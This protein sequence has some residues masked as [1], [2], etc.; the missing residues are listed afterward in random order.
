MNSITASTKS[1]GLDQ[2]IW[3]MIGLIGLFAVIVVKEIALPS[4]VVTA[5]GA[6][7]LLGLFMMGIQYPEMPFY[8]LVAYVPFSKILTGDFGTQAFALNMTNILT[9]WALVA[10]VLKRGAQGQALFS[11]TPLNRVV[12]LFCFL[13]AFS[14]IMAGFQYGSGYFLS[15]L[16]PLKRWF[17]PV[18]FY[19]L[20]LWIARDRRTIKTTTALMMVVV[21]VAALMAI[22]EYTYIE[23]GRLE[24]SRVGGIAEHS[25]T[26]AAFFVY[27]MF[28]FLGFFLVYPKRFGVWLLLVPFLLCFRGIMVTFSRGAYVAFAAAGMAACWFR[29][30]MLFLAAI[31]LGVGMLINPIFLPS[32]IRYRMSSLVVDPAATG[33][34]DLEQ[35]LEG[36]SSMRLRIWKGAIQM[37]KDHPMWGVGYGAF[38]EFIAHYAEGNIGLRDAHNSYLLVAAEMGLP[39]LIVFLLILAMIWHYTYWLY[40][41]SADRAMRAIALGFLSGLTGLLVANMFGSRMDS[42]EVSSYF[43]MLCGLVMRAVTIERAEARGVTT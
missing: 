1:Q 12:L 9:V 31:L 17:T 14:L 40:R 29:H 18:F 22:R 16:T 30:K 8:V 42:Q 32:G 27:Y 37:I 35:N 39:T 3:P 26:L 21:T 11:G 24:S 15:F 19:F 20:A 13:G 28:L 36:S 6:M 43:W 10:Y 34:I 5:F 41:H 2:R 33:A 38:P 4:V 7:G 25:N 23:G